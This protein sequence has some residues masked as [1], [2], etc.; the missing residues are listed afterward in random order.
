MDP[1]GPIL[2]LKTM[3]DQFVVMVERTFPQYT[4]FCLETVASVGVAPHEALLVK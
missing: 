3:D 4:A 1:Q 2:Y